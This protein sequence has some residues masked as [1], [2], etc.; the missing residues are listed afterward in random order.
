MITTGSLWT[1]PLL[2]KTSY[3]PL[4]DFAP[5]S[6]LVTQPT[7]LVVHPSLPVKSLAELVALAKDH[8]PDRA[9]RTLKTATDVL[10]AANAYLG[11]FAVTALVCWLGWAGHLGPWGAPSALAIPAVYVS[12]DMAEVS[13]GTSKAAGRVSVGFEGRRPEGRPEAGGARLREGDASGESHAPPHAVREARADHLRPYSG[14]DRPGA[15]HRESL[16]REDGLRD[17][18]CCRRARRDQIGRAHV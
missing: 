15:V 3:D 6:M 10:A 13:E 14:A 5:I 9:A 17:R 8:L 11:L 4:R 18:R 2:Q 12:H 1:A 7:L 16:V